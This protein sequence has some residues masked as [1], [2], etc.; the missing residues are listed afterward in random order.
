MYDLTGL[1]LSNIRCNGASYGCFYKGTEVINDKKYYYKCSNFYSG[2]PAFGDES[3]YEVICSRLFEKLGLRHTKYT[4][5]QAKVQL[6]GRTF[7]THLCKSPDFSTGFV[8]RMTLGSYILTNGYVS[9]NEVIKRFKLQDSINQMLIADF[10]TIQRDRHE[11]NI[12]LLSDKNGR[13]QLAPLFD[14]GLSF[15][16]PYPV[17]Y[18]QSSFPAVK[19][20]NPLRDV[21]VNNY[22]GERSLGLNLSL[23]SKPVV[24]RKLD[25]TSLSSLFYGMSS[26]LPDFYIAKIKEIIC[27]RYNY[28]KRG[29]HI[30]ET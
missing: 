2:L 6:Q 22:M 9:V 11:N 14:N 27:A 23:I 4:L 16:A 18:K 15:L 1:R 28:L 7:I 21:E 30:I 29:G 10:L 5:I 13:V 24:V 20:F 17:C 25:L 19:E 3:C 26:V 8:S 12:E